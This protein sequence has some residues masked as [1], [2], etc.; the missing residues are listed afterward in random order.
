MLGCGGGA[1]VVDRAIAVLALVKALG[2]VKGRKRLQKIVHLLGA[3]GF[4]DFPQDFR[5]H[6]FGP[7]SRELASDLD[8]LCAAKLVTEKK[9][10]HVYT[11]RFEPGEL[12]ETAEELMA[13]ESQPGQWDEFARR[14]G[15]EQ[16]PMLE[17][18]STLVYLAQ[19]GRKDDSLREEFKTLKPHLAS[20]FDE[21][22]ELA[23]REELV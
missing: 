9:S 13:S 21:A 20:R 23:K 5:L 18:A 16:T 12:G 10:D 8:F 1:I 19:A 2:E 6:Y 4:R 14:L 3:K 17:A 7:F 11:Y 15:K 22:M